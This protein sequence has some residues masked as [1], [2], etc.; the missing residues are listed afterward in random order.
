MIAV[1][2]RD[3]L[4]FW[5]GAGP[6]KWFAR[7]DALDADIRRRFG[8]AHAAA[9]EGRLDEWAQDAQGALALVILLDQFSRNLF[10]DDHRAWAQD[11][12]ALAV[13]REAIGRRFDVEVPVTVRQWFYLPFMH[14][15]D[16]AAQTEGLAYFAGR[17]QGPEDLKWAE[18]HADI[19]RR[20]GRFPHRNAVLGRRTTPEEQSFLD[21]GGFKG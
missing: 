1:R 10:R 14:A 15:E 21:A 20:F 6:D 16:L 2:P 11:E 12:K 9:C 13:T 19:I 18:E 4:D 5:F 7:D 17:L 3:I 8:A